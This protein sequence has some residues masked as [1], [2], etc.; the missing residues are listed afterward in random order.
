MPSTEYS[1]AERQALLGIARAS[2]A[3]G[4]A[5]GRPLPLDA[6]QLPD[7]LAAH[8]ATFITLTRDGELRGC[9]GALDA[10]RPLAVDVAES[11]CRTALRDPRFAPVRQAELARIVIEV[12]VLS[13]LVDLPVR[14]QRDLYARLTPGVDG[15]VLRAGAHSATFLPKVWEHLG[16][17]ERFVGELKR[18]AGLPQDFWSAAVRLY[19]YRTESFAEAAT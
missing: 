12:S 17:P 14:D 8:R 3:H 1:S 11:A 7:K 5:A 18:K 4:V 9:T 15:L 10:T 6:E 19:R 2:M 16:T 13:P